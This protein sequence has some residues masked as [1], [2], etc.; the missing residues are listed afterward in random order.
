MGSYYR[1]GNAKCKILRK[2]VA[3]FSNLTL[4]FAHGVDLLVVIK[5]A[6]PCVSKKIENSTKKVRL[7]ENMRG[8]KSAKLGCAVLEGKLDGK[9]VKKS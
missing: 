7:G 4:S 3:Y 5:S 9:R 1:V 2:S 8:Q 6:V